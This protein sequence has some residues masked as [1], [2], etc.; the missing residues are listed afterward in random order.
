MND[1]TFIVWICLI[2][3]LPAFWGAC[4]LV[5]WQI[6]EWRHRRQLQR[7]RAVVA[8]RILKKY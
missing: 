2:C 3:L 8:Q 5:A 6:A 7:D 1:L 4:R